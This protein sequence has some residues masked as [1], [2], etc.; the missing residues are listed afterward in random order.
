[1]YVLINRDEMTIP[2]KH[3]S[4]RVLADLAWIEIKNNNYHI[5]PVESEASFVEFTPMEL[6]MLYRNITNSEPPKV[7]KMQLVRVIFSLVDKIKETQATEFE[8]ETQAA[9]VTEDSDANWFYVFGS[10]A[11]GK[12]NGLF[13]PPCKAVKISDIEIETL[14]NRKEPA[15]SATEKTANSNTRVSNRSGNTPSKGRELIWKIADKQWEEHGKPIDKQKILAIRK[16]IMDE[17]EMQGVKRTSASSELGKWQK[18]QV[19]M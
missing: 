7:S 14:L 10:F 17:L 16:L 1:M 12:K 6:E 3:Q 13:S 4:F 18:E 19:G 15:N 11:P 2:H 5:V 8:A 9:K